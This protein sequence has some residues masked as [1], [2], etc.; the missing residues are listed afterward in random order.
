[1]IKVDILGQRW[2]ITAVTPEAF[3]KRFGEECQG[4]TIPNSREVVVNSDDLTIETVRHELWH[5]AYEC[6]CVSTA[7]LKKIQMEE[8]NCEL[9]SLHGESLLKLARK[10]YKEL[11]NC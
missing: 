7:S 6:L 1:M 2:T 3:I 10:L 11:R 8:V 5:A 4:M 9:F